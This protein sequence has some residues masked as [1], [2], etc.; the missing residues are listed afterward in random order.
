MLTGSHCSILDLSYFSAFPACVCAFVRAFVCFLYY[1]NPSLLLLL[2]PPAPPTSGPAQSTLDHSCWAGDPKCVNQYP[3]YPISASHRAPAEP[4][5]HERTTV[6][7]HRMPFCDKDGPKGFE[8]SHRSR[9]DMWKW[10][11]ST[12][13]CYYSFGV[14]SAHVH[15]HVC[16]CMMTCK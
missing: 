6:L 12:S 14:W 4:S 1:S 3:V 2:S 13:K 15:T 8:M 16:A 5:V 9:V 11:I 7:I 10:P